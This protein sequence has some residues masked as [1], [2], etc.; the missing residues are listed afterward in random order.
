MNNGNNYNNQTNSLNSKKTKSVGNDAEGIALSY[1]LNKGLRLITKNFYSR[2]GEID[3]IMR[4][5]EYIVFVEVRKRSGGFDH[6]LES[7]TYTK[8]QKLIRTAKYYL[9]KIGYDVCCRFD[10]IAID[11][12]NNCN[13]L[14]NVITL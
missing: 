14:K 9:S 7:I 2:F 12:G 1:L 5:A 10:V 8:Q 3:I 6:A 4:D 13:W 11:H